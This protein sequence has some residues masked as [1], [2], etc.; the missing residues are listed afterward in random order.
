MRSAFSVAL[1]ASLASSCLAEQSPGMVRLEDAAGSERP[2][3]LSIWY[4]ATD[5]ASEEIGGNAVFKGGFGAPNAPVAA[6][7]FPLI[8]MSHGGLRSANDSG[9]WLSAALA[10]AGFIVAEINAPRPDSAQSAVDEIWRRPG[11]ISRAVDLMLNSDAW[12]DHI[13]PSRVSAVGFALGGAAALAVA[14]GRADV[15]PFLRACDDISI[16]GPDCAWYAAQ[17]VALSSVDQK[18]LARSR[19]DPRITSA[20]AINPEY[21]SVFSDGMALVEIPALVLSLGDGQ[22]RADLEGKLISEVVISDLHSFDGF[23]ACTE[24]GPEVLSEEEGDPA[25]CGVSAEA[26]ERA[27]DEIARQIASFLTSGGKTTE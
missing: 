14:G 24:A 20:V 3:V 25:I 23:P 6:G 13:E 15:R 5:G 9:A 7:R 17:D 4:P 10:R 11:D 1:F 26:R 8:L 12:A 19:H 2:L 22:P 27:H 21:M 18:E 16:A